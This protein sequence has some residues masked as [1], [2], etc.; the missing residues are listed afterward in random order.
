MPPRSVLRDISDEMNHEQVIGN[1]TKKE[2]VSRKIRRERG[3]VLERP[4]IPTDYVPF[5]NMP[6]RYTKTSDG[7]DFLRAVQ[8]T[9][10]PDSQALLLFLSDHGKSLLK[11]YRSWNMDGTFQ[12]C[13]A[14]FS[15]L[16]FIFAITDTGK[17]IP[18]AYS[19]LPNKKCYGL[20]F[21]ELKKIIE[22]TSHL[23]K[24]MVDFEKG[25]HRQI[26]ESFPNASVSGCLF[27]YK[28]AVRRQLGAKGCMALYNADRNF[29]TL[30]SMLYS[31]PFVPSHEVVHVFETVVQPFFE[32]CADDWT[33]EGY[34]EETGDFFK[35]FERT[36]IGLSTRTGRRNP[37]FKIETWNHHCEVL[38]DDFVVTNN[39]I[40]SFNSSRTPSIPRNASIWSVL[41]CLN[42]EDSMSKVTY[43]EYLRGTN[44]AHNKSRDKNNRA[45]T[46]EL[47]SICEKWM[48]FDSKDY[49]EAIRNFYKH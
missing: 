15:Q 39:G 37:L 18:A 1:M 3:K 35:Y 6:D 46:E 24:V 33:E 43:M 26:E 47:K 36:Y 5:F 21:E 34:D 17:T 23:E 31:L 19:L 48:E 10:G 27:H 28:Q 13:P 4:T 22:E 8:W 42:K 25:V 9:D 38:K 44:Q 41:E 29:Q 49:L 14:Q 32:D 40:E 11:T 45:K 12:T 20:L 2:S 7:G 16:Y 30:V